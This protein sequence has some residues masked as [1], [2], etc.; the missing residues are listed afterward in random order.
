[1]SERWA[2]EVDIVVSRQGDK[3]IL[4]SYEGEE[5]WIPKSLIE[6]DDYETLSKGDCIDLDIPLWKAEELGWEE[7]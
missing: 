5:Q 3:A 4:V 6:G 1:M 7:Q 2:D